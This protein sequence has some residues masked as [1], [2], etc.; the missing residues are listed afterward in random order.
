MFHFANAYESADGRWLHIDASVYD[1][2]AVLNDLALDRVRRGP[3]QGSEISHSHLRR[4][5]IDLHAP[6]G[7]TWPQHAAFCW[8]VILC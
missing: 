4:L 5:T 7:E 1:D 6:S 8:E 3:A 2:P